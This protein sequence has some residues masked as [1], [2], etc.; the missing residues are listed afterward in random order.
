VSTEACA[1]RDGLILVGKNGCN[2]MEFNLD[3]LD[4]IK[5]MQ[6]GGNSLGTA[7]LL[8]RLSQNRMDTVFG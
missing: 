6:N 3:C 7:M 5:V 4:M 1:L 2:S 8:L